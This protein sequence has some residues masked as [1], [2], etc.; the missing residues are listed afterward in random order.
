MSPSKPAAPTGAERFREVDA[1]SH[2]ESNPALLARNAALLELLPADARIV[3]DVGSGP[4]VTGRALSAAGRTVI[5]LDASRAALRLGPPHP[6]CAAVDTLPVSDR[7]VDLALCLEV[8][9]HLPHTVLERAARELDR[10]A[11]HWLILGVPDREHL[12]RNHLRCPRC[13]ERFHRSGHIHR[14]D[15]AALVSHF[16]GWNVRGRWRGGPRVRDYPPPL[17]WIRQEVARSFCEMGG[18]D[19]VSCPRCG[20]TAFPR[21]AHNPLSFA[22][23]GLTRVFVRRRAYWLVLLLARSEAR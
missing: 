17:L 11:R 19:G 9:E 15:E 2:Y 1:Y 20:E 22:L 18:G 10:I 5:S 8:L 16:P 23:D 7:A 21:F 12:K 14:F 6:V 3:C 13:G 4:G